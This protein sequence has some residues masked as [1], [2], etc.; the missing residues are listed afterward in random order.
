MADVEGRPVQ[1]ALCPWLDEEMPVVD[2]I[3]HVLV[4]AVAQSLRPVVDRKASVHIGLLV[5]LPSSRPGL[6]EDLESSISASVQRL[7]PHAFS[8]V[9]LARRGHAGALMALRSGV[10]AV[11]A[12]KVEAC[13]VVGADSYLD[14]E[15]LDWLEETEQLHGAGA[16]NNAWGFVPGEAAGAVLLVRQDVARKLDLK[17]FG[18]IAAVGIDVEQNLIRTGSVCLGVGLTQAFRAAFAALEPGAQITDIY[19]DMNGEPYRADEYGFAV[20]RTRE[21]FRSPSE[22]IA[23][24]DCWGDVGAASAPLSLLLAMVASSKQYARGDVAL[25]WASS[26]SGERGAAL[27]AAG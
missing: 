4:N 16:R 9:V 22:F 12:R 6:P 1:V 17:P 23:P 2:R 3:Q 14:L 10:A 26:D 20:T 24:A 27:V 5:N 21:H 15:T 7:S 25:V 19:C 13:I 11:A 8:S 18:R